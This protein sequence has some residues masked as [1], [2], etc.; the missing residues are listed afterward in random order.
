M[1]IVLYLLRCEYVTYKPIPTGGNI[2][3][4]YMYNAYA[5]LINKNYYYV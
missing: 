5:T 4:N 2:C 1:P 3:I